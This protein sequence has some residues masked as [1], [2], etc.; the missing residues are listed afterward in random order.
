MHQSRG[1]ERDVGLLIVG[2]ACCPGQRRLQARKVTELVA[3]LR[4]G[5]PEDFGVQPDDVPGFEE[6]GL[7]LRVGQA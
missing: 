1:L 2:V 6:Y 7:L 3:G 5:A 4:I